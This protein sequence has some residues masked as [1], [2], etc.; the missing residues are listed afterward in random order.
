MIVKGILS[1]ILTGIIAFIFLFCM[2][3]CRATK[4]SK[5]TSVNW[6]VKQD[7]VRKAD[8]MRRAAMMEDFI[9]SWSSE[10]TTSEPVAGSSV[11]LTE[12]KD[13]PVNTTVR[14]GNTTLT[15]TTDKQ[16]NRHFECKADSMQQVITRKT[17][18]SVLLHRRYDSLYA[19]KSLVDK[20]S[21]SVGTLKEVVEKETKGWLT[22]TKPLVFLVLIVAVLFFCIGY[23]CKGHI[24]NNKLL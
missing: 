21:D 17:K 5:T 2:G 23:M 14:N 13:Q 9:R 19:I 11:S 4:G 16:G 24:L 22:A 18:D 10:E 7:S 6:E 8:S 1:V 20:R 3:S 12:A 15:T